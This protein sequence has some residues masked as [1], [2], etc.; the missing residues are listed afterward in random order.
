MLLIIATLL[1][2]MP[3]T[4]CYLSAMACGL[5]K[6]GG[7]VSTAIFGYARFDQTALIRSSHVLHGTALPLRNAMCTSHFGAVV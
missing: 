5:Q 4:S 3:T 6:L 1:P 2:E 7:G